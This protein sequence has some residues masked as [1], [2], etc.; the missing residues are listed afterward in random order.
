MG[1]CTETRDR[2]AAYCDG[3]DGRAERADVERHLRECP[4]CADEAARLRATL[5]RVAA[6]P[7]VDPSPE[8]WEA[9]AA[10][11]ECRLAATPPPVASAWA[12]LRIRLGDLTWLQ[13]VQALGAA[14]ALGVLLTIGL[15][16]SPRLPAERPTVDPVAVSES[17]R[18]GRYLEVLEQFEL[19]EDLDLL[20]TLPTPAAGNG[21]THRVA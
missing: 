14:A 6:L 20:E 2:L 5:I 18:I 17:L 12:R 10:E 19:L 15:V 9:F 1:E 7:A 21:R 11:L 16:Q 13:P 8:F 3:A 4:A